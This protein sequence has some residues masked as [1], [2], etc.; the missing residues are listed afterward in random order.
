MLSLSSQPPLQSKLK[1]PQLIDRSLLCLQ[2]PIPSL[3]R[4]T[5]QTQS[6][7]GPQLLQPP[8]VLGKLL[9]RTTLQIFLVIPP[10]S[11]YHPIR[12]SYN[13]VIQSG[14]NPTDMS[15]AGN[16]VTTNFA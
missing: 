6:I 15:G 1:T 7:P 10:P 3:L 16:R 8:F 2:N 13:L 11:I 12:S 14:E 4:H 5:P 9:I